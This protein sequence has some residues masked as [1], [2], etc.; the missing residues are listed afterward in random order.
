MDPLNSTIE[1]NFRTHVLTPEQQGQLDDYRAAVRALAYVIDASVPP[2]R[3]K[4]L[5]LTN[6]EQVMFWGGAGIA[7][8]GGA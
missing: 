8:H 2:G 1:T 6:L 4:S 3:E 5:A 7:R